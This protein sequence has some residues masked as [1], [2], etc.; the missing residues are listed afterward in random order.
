[1]KLDARKARVLRAVVEEH[2]DTGLPVGSRVIAK[3]YGLGVS[4][5]TIRNEM[6][7]LEE[8]GYLDK[9]HASSGRVPSDQGYRLYVDELMPEYRLSPEDTRLVESVFKSRVRDVVS[10]LKETVK[11]VADTSNYLAFVLGPE[12]QTTMYKS[13]YLLPAEPGTALLVIVTDVGLVETCLIS[14]AHMSKEELEYV[15]S[16]LAR[17]LTYVSLDKVADRAYAL[18]REETS[19]YAILIDQVVEFLRSIDVETDR[20]YFGGAANL[21]NHPEFHDV[22]RFKEVL[23]AIE[24]EKILQIILDQQSNE[25]DPTISIGDEIELGRQGDL[26]MVYGTFMVGSNEGKIGILGPKRM[27]Y[28]HVV[29]ILRFCEQQL[30]KFFS[31]W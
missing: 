5:A 22:T 31:R 20:L 15:S 4:P 6:A 27:D 2:I 26:S 3:R 18:L 23:T 16:M 14:T 24:S 21:L 25:K 8:T 11:T 12:F 10:L 29:A 13:I 7:D 1:V 9:P 30:T 28:S 19:R 17:E